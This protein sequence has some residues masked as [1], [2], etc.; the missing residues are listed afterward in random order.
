MVIR[1]PSPV[2]VVKNRYD[3]QLEYYKSSRAQPCGG[4]SCSDMRWFVELVSVVHDDQ[5]ASGQ[6]DPRQNRLHF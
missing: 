5:A 6:N 1:T 3:G 2:N 4:L